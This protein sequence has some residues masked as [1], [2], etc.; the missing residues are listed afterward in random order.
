MST[1]LTATVHAATDYGIAAWLP[2]KPLKYFIKQLTTIDHIC[3]RA[4]LGALPSTPAVFL[5]Q[6][7]NLTPAKARVQA[8]IMNF[9]AVALTKPSHSPLHRF[10]KQAQ[11]TNP[12]SHHNPFHWFFRHPVSKSL[13]KH[14]HQI[15]LD[16]TTIL[17]RP[18]NFTTIIQGNKLMAKSDANSLT[19]TLEHVVIFT[20][21]SRIPRETTAAAA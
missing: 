8:K 3:A 17:S 9:M 2:L 7:L 11:N 13:A 18:T 10:V 14:I 19:A 16:P 15:P 12:K 6:D 21:G 5:A 4:A 1:L 20:D